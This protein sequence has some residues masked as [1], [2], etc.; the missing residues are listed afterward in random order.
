ME[1][2]LRDLRYFVAVAERLHFTQAAA[3]LEIG[4]PT[5]SR[6]IQQLERHLGT[7]L[8]DRNQRSVALTVAGRELLVGARAILAQWEQT[9]A[10]LAPAGDGIRL[11]MM[12]T[13]EFGL[14]E[15][16][17]QRSSSPV[18]VY[19]STYADPSVG[20]DSRK[21]DVSIILLPLTRPENYRW[22]KVRREPRWVLLPLKHRLAGES[23]VHFADIAD[24]PFLAL[25]EG[26][27]IL[28]DY[29]VGNDVREGSK[30]RI[31]GIAS[32]ADE[33]VEAV[34]LGVGVVLLPEFAMP[35]HRWPGTVMRRVVDIPPAELVLA[36]RADD[37]RAA[38]T[39]FIDEIYGND[40]DAE[41]FPE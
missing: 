5:L 13:H 1:P 36:W 29:W 21:S 39:R 38:V 18:V 31:S 30:A 11:G 32:T 35:A 7:V 15:Q 41:W 9:R 16:M 33:R 2:S 40:P 27:G 8:F 24:E 25:P 19:S 12:F 22:R 6:Q 37:D 20:L 10:A 3:D 17:E 26:A 28:R 23:E 14:L 34:E 4:Q